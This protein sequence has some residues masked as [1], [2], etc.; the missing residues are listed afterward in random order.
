MKAHPRTALAGEAIT[1]G[2]RV[3]AIADVLDALT[4]GRQYPAEMSV[5][6]AD[7]IIRNNSGTHFDP[8]MEEAYLAVTRRDQ[9]R[10]SAPLPSAAP[11]RRRSPSAPTRGTRS[12][13]RPRGTK[14]S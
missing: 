10:S 6:L 4:S 12:W 2:A 7:E 5:E 14:W 11:P 13:S 8:R 9:Y 3:L 1:L